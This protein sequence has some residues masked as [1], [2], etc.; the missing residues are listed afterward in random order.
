MERSQALHSHTRKTEITG[1]Y[2]SR[3]LILFTDLW[4]RSHQCPKDGRALLTDCLEVI[5]PE[6]EPCG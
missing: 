4:F 3:F 1:R 6:E 2:L 5:H